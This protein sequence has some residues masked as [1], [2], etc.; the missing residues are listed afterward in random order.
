MCVFSWQAV[1]I[2]MSSHAAFTHPASLLCE[3][4]VES[5]D[6]S[7]AHGTLW[8]YFR[9]EIRGAGRRRQRV[10]SGPMWQ[11]ASGAANEANGWP[12]LG[13][14]VWMQL[15]LGVVLLRGMWIFRWC[16]NVW[17]WW[18]GRRWEGRREEGGGDTEGATWHWW[19]PGPHS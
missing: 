7:T 12:Y 18:E 1:I 15:R 17:V 2:Q 14:A 11:V 8:I 16:Q 10:K 19:K 9:H 3:Q 13:T 5:Q 6:G 4:E